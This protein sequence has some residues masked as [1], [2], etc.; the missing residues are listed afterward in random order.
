VRRQAVTDELAG[1]ANHGRSQELLT[2]EI[3][4]VR[5]YHHPIG[6][7]LDVDDV[8]AVNDTYGHQ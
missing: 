1:L 2:A 7:M 3:E 6:I 5:R 8:K 4:R